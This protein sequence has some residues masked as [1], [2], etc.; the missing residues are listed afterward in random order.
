MTESGA[1]AGKV[2]ADARDRPAGTEPDITR[3]RRFAAR[4]ARPVVLKHRWSVAD[5][6]LAGI[7]AGDWWRLLRENG[8][9]VDPEYWHRALFVT[10]ISLVRALFTSAEKHRYH[11]MVEA[12]EIREPPLFI[13]GYWRSGTAHLQ[14]LLS[15]DIE[16]FAFANTY[17]VF[18]PRIFLSTEE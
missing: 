14:N 17:Q 1:R 7:S 8:F 5:N 11:A 12:V 18:N 9:A 13:L 16:Q 10:L 15:Q 4:R 6:Y 3:R 2:A